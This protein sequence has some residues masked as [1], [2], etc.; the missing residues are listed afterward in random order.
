VAVELAG[1]IGHH[2]KAAEKNISLLVRGEK[3]LGQLDPKAGEIAEEQLKTLNIQ[4][5]Y[6][7]PYTESL[8][9]EKGYDLVL[10]CTGQSYNS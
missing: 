8:K 3:L 1:E 7:T 4:I 6:K 10:E 2:S 9:K 5:N